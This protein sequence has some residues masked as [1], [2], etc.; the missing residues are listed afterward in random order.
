ML[1]NAIKVVYVESYNDDNET[2]AAI[3]LTESDRFKNLSFT[4]I[5]STVIKHFISIEMEKCSDGST[6]FG[7][8]F[9]DDKDFTACLN[10]WNKAYLKGEI[11]RII[12][13]LP[14]TIRDIA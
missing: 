12:N 14:K 4:A 6:I 10:T 3:R 11:K 8:T 7:A 13:A 9:W 5:T 2:L 1:I